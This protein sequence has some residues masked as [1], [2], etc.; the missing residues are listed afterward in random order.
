VYEAFDKAPTDSYS[1][2]FGKIFFGQV[3]NVVNEWHSKS[4]TCCAGYHKRMKGR[5]K[6]LIPKVSEQ[7]E[8]VTVD[9]QKF[10]AMLKALLRSGPIPQKAVQNRVRSPRKGTARRG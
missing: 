4:S 8:D 5:G 7:G 2:D 9:A 3:G 6:Y 1:A 10:D